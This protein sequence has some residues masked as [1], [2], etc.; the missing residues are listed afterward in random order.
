MRRTLGLRGPRGSLLLAAC[1]LTF[2]V[3]C[4]SLAVD[5]PESDSGTQPDATPLTCADSSPATS[6]LLT[7]AASVPSNPA[8]NTLVLYELQVRSANSCD[9]AFGSPEQRRACEESARPTA[10]SR[11]TDSVC[12]LADDF[13]AIRLGTF[14]DLIVDTADPSV[15]ISMR[16]V[17]ENVGANAVW[18]QPVFPNND[19]RLLPDRCDTLGSPYAVRDYFH[20]RGTLSAECVASG[21]D[22]YAEPPCWGDSAFDAL[23]A[24]AEAR[25]VGVFLDV[26]LNHFGHDYLFY[27][28]ANVQPIR[29]RLASAPAEELWDFEATFDEALLWPEVAEGE[30]AFSAEI[31]AEVEDICPS[32]SPQELVRAAAMYTVAFDDERRSFECRPTLEAALPAFY[33]A[34][35]NQGFARAESQ[36]TNA[37]GWRDVKFLFH[38]SD[39]TSAQREFLR[40]R[41]Y[42][43]RIVNYWASRGVDGFRLD[44]ATDWLSGMSAQEWRYITEKVEYYAALRGDPAP[45]WL[46]EEFHSQDAMS[47]VADIL[48]EGYLFGITSRAGPMG[49]ADV[50][51]TLDSV[52]R[53]ASGAHV[54]THL[55]NHDELRLSD[56]TPWD[57]WTGAGVWALGASARS[58]PMLLVG[59]EWGEPRRLEFRRPHVLLGRFDG[60]VSSQEAQDLTQ[61]YREHIALRAQLTALRS[62]G[63]RTLLSYDGLGPGDLAVATL[64][65]AGDGE[66]VLTVNNLWP[67]DVSGDWVIP[68]DLRAGLGIEPCEEVRFRNARTDSVIVPCTEAA[69][70]ADGFRFW[71]PSND[72]VRWAV[73]ERCQ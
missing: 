40:V 63:R 37:Y 39:N 17:A 64:R 19:R 16:Y 35:D 55:E 3:G 43:F 54:L 15:A 69:L 38:R 58:V 18:L 66:V 45:V 13:A 46:A 14:D 25:G 52:Y 26:A 41:E 68:P 36:T 30:G 50:H 33:L 53:F 71:L 28:V 29:E 12:E 42:A 6:S 34:S 8:L 62:A 60:T 23:L 21:S 70:L 1:T 56:G 61:F 59:Q 44:H 72:R 5:S 24:D 49:V 48:T 73:M 31:W 51:R 7:S 67:L 4:S 20:T 22:E 32:L 11:A 9:P 65:W 10:W 2:W 57:V 47:E 27:D